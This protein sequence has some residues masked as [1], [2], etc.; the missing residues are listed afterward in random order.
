MIEIDDQILELDDLPIPCLPKE[1]PSQAIQVLDQE[2][3]GW[4]VQSD[5]LSINIP[6]TE[7]KKKHLVMVEIERDD[8][9]A[10]YG[11]YGL[12]RGF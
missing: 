4:P 2:I 11:G 3:V 6:D 12:R 1:R 10:S 5:N 7:S 8:G 9:D